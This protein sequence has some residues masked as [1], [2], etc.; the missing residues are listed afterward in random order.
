MSPIGEGVERLT[1]LLEGLVD[2]AEVPDLIVSDLTMSSQEAGSGQ[3]FLAVRGTRMHGLA[4]AAE[5]VA[6][7]A[8][9]VIYESC[10]LYTS[11][12]P[13]DA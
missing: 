1:E 10:L 7:G 11:P 8:S 2:A 12:S 4:F 6:R 9:C 5:A 3:A 13:R